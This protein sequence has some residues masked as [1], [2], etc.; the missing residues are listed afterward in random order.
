MDYFWNYAFLQRG[1]AMAILGGGVCG[2]MGVFV[3][4]WRMSLV[5][6]SISH[7]AF[8]GALLSLMLGCPPL[9]GGIIAS[10]LAAA[11]VG[12]LAE[13]PGFSPD[14]AMGVIFSVVMGLAVMILGLMPGARTEGLSL[15]WGSLLT[16]DSLDLRLMACTAAGLILFVFLFFKEIQAIIGQRRSAEAAGIPV[17]QIYYACLMLMGLTVAFSLKAIGGFLIFSLIVTPAAT[18][19]QITYSLKSMFFLSALFGAA[20]SSTGLWLSYEFALPPG[21]AIVLVAT[22]GLIAA[23]VLSPKKRERRA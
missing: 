10:L 2:A 4:L 22:T 11:I 1:L 21:A 3:V 8:A 7:A 6:M 5:G 19:L 15:V 14:T 13:R 18:A 23:M 17:R 20:A 16:V 9:A 12:P